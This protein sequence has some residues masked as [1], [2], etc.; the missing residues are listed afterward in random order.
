M[1]PIPK[2]IGLIAGKG[3]YPRLTIEGA[4]KAGITEI[5]MAAFTNET[6]EEVINLVDK[7]EVVRVGQLGRMIKFFRKNGVKQA[8]MAGQ[9]TPGNLFD[10][11][12]DIRTLLLLGKLKRKNAESIFG[13]I[14]DE[15]LKDG[16]ELLPATTFIEDA[17]VGEGHCFGPPF[18][19]RQIGDAHFAMGLAKQVSALDIGQSLVVRHGT[20]LAVE[21]FE[22]TNDCVRRG[23]A[24]GKG[25]AL[26]A[27]V[28][29]PNQDFRFDVPV[30]GPDTIRVAAE[31]GVM[32]IV[33]ESGKTLVLDLPAVREAC[34]DLGVSVMGIAPS[35]RD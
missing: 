16:I 11:R 32:A 18:S 25:Q 24:M 22:G 9:I 12:P 5:V 30:I 15:L 31:A 13:A 6:S 1:T 34:K 4:R 21:A 17:L 7:H 29:K 2:S 35:D 8:I 33:L 23:G 14:A 10:L 27:K 20:V 26:L 19:E 3:I 28:S